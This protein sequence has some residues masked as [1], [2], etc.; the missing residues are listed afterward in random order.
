VLSSNGRTTRPRIKALLF[1]MSR[2]K[3]VSGSAEV[4]DPVGVNLLGE[5]THLTSA[6]SFHEVTKLNKRPVHGGKDYFAAAYL[7][8]TSSQFTALQNAAM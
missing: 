2:R 5:P 8:A 7:F 4:V 6:H 3:T 1:G